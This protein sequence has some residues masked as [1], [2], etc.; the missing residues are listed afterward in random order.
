MEDPLLAI[1]DQHVLAQDLG[2]KVPPIVRF[3]E[4]VAAIT[5]EQIEAIGRATPTAWKCG[6]SGEKLATLL[7]VMRRRRDAIEKWLPQVEARIQ[8]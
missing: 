8:R 4:A 7:D 1:V 2:R 3:R 5:D 6:T